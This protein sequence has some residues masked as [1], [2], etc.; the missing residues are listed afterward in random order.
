MISAMSNTSDVTP[1]NRKFVNKEGVFDF[2]SCAIEYC[3]YDC[4]LLSKVYRAF[5]KTYFDENPLLK[6]GYSKFITAGSLTIFTYLND[7]EYQEDVKKIVYIKPGS[8]TYSFIKQGFFG[9][10]TEIFQITPQNRESKVYYYDFSRIYGN[11][12]IEKLPRLCPSEFSPGAGK[13]IIDVDIKELIDFCT[14]KELLGFIRC[15]AL[16]PKDTVLPILPVKALIK[17][18]TQEGRKLYFPVG[19]VRNRV[20]STAEI[21]LALETG[22]T[23]SHIRA[24]TLFDADD[25]LK[26]FS[27]KILTEKKKY[28]ILG[29]KPLETLYKLLNNSLYGKF[30]SAITSTEPLLVTKYRDLDII[31]EEKSLKEQKKSG[32]RVVDYKR[33]NERLFLVILRKN[34]RVYKGQENVAI[35]AY[36]T[37]LGR[38]KL[39]RTI[40]DVLKNNPQANLIYC[41]TDSI[42][43]ESPTPMKD[44]RTIKS[45]E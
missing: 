29:N 9:G 41:D 15:R 18:E 12:M 11:I 32:T 16:I 35:S 45:S 34:K 24:I 40:I 3:D 14:S 8:K 20:W 21:K 26:K 13:H 5:L 10:R 27:L 28:K 43:F 2:W 38:V 44:S 7:P 17:G 4:E 19:F 36:I 31:I 39:N 42:F 33:L 22:V 25:P 23:F 37:A 30:G 6:V 1:V